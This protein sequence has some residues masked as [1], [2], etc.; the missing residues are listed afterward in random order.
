MTP[1][2]AVPSE[3]RTHLRSVAGIVLP[4]LLLAGL[5]ILFSDLALHAMIEDDTARQRIGMFKGWFFVAVTGALLAVLVHDADPARLVLGQEAGR[6]GGEV[7]VHHPRLVVARE[8]ALLVRTCPCHP[9]RN[10]LADARQVVEVLPRLV[11]GAERWVVVEAH[12]VDVGRDGS[13]LLAK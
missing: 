11:R 9:I 13:A 3:Q 12:E 7:V 8:V 5:W 6:V 10:L 1:R 4:Y 2:N